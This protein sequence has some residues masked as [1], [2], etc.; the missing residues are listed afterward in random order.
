MA[1]QSRQ[2]CCELLTIILMK[3]ALN[4]ISSAFHLWFLI[5]ILIWLLKYE[6]QS[7]LYS[8]RVAMCLQYFLRTYNFLFIS[9]FFFSLCYMQMVQI[10]LLILSIC[11]DTSKYRIVQSLHFLFLHFSL[12]KAACGLFQT[13]SALNCLLFSGWFQ[14]VAASLVA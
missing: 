3:F 1:S 8:I 12:Y 13:K 14:H 5:C 11:K 6:S 9:C 4:M 7:T 2:F 10:Q